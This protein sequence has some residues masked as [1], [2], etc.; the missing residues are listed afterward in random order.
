MRREQESSP[1]EKISIP[2]K[3][4]FRA[5]PDNLLEREQLYP[6]RRQWDLSAKGLAEGVSVLVC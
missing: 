3:V 6:G 4:V 5:L 2:G 1:F